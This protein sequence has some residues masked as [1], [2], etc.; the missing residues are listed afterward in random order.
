M[1]VQARALEAASL[2]VP[3]ITAIPPLWRLRHLLLTVSTKLTLQ[4]FEDLSTPMTLPEL[5]TPAAI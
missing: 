3:D 2:A 5:R 4:A 1:L